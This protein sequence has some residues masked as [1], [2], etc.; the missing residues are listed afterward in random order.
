MTADAHHDLVTRLGRK[1]SVN[2]EA[3]RRIEGEFLDDAKIIV[4]SFGSTARSARK[5]VRMAREQNVPVGFVR[6][7]S[8]WPFPEMMMKD[9][10]KQADTFIVA[11]MNLGQVAHEVQ[12]HV[13]Q[14]VLGVHHAG[15]AMMHPDKI[16]EVILG[17]ANND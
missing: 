13:H 8:V 15:G 11:E 3:I 16:L 6:L 17:A 1:I 7:I 12:R 4:I 2:A 10:A 9:L 14:P 5:A